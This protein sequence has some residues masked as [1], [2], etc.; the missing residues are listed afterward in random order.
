MNKL[1]VHLLKLIAKLPLPFA[2]AIGTLLGWLLIIMPNKNRHITSRNLE[3]CLPE[4]DRV[5]RK[6]LIRKSL[7]E[8]GKAVMEKGAIMCWKQKR[9][10][11][12][13]Q[14]VV[15][16][17]YLEHAH[18]IDKGTILAIP[19]LGDWEMVGLYCSNRYPM[20]SLYRPLR[21][22]L[23]NFIKKGRE[24]L[25][26]QLV[27]TKGQG[28]RALY[29]ALEK[30][31]LVAILPDQNPGAGKGLYVPFFGI[32]ANTMVLLSRLATKTNAT[33]LYA[34]AERLSAGKGFRLHFSPA[35]KEVHDQDIVKSLTA[36]NTGLEKCIRKLPEQYWWSYPRFRHRPEGEQSVY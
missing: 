13:V 27:P 14:E 36:L 31:E 5:H 11:E 25:G 24:R 16:L 2:H 9:I 22:P 12:M 1:S 8:T 28:L 20:T 23:D 7:I 21:G 15:G 3:L 18:N 32:K 6:I 17:E 10:L 33:V 4:L 35:P 30:G 34:Y 29:S 26:A 19:H